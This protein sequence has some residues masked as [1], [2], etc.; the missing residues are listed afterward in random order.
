MDICRLLFGEPVFF[1]LKHQCTLFLGSNRIPTG[2]IPVNHPPKDGWLTT[3]NRELERLG[4][5][6]K[7]GTTPLNQ[8]K[9][10]HFTMFP[11]T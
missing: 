10:P 8:G 2:Q 1:G 3:R 7:P 9:I 11:S 6:R 4:S 5:G